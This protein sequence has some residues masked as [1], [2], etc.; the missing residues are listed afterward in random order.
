M[1]QNV[2]VPERVEVPVEIPKKR[3]L[4]SSRS[5]SS[6]SELKSVMKLELEETVL[7]SVTESLESSV[8]R[9]TPP[10]VGVQEAEDVFFEMGY[11]KMSRCCF[12]KIVFLTFMLMLV[13]TA[14]N[15]YDINRDAY[16]QRIGIYLNS[17]STLA[18]ATRKRLLN[19]RTKLFSK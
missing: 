12:M 11:L 16:Q 5:T 9:E 4:R 8:V 1:E 13:L 6:T 17:F 7:E 18:E 10:T 3:Q 2:E 14:I 19:F 15:H